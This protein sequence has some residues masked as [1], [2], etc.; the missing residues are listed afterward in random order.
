[1]TLG[2]K[3]DPYRVL[4]W[5]DDIGPGRGPGKRVVLR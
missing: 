3:D 2:G 1:M 5:Q 4:S